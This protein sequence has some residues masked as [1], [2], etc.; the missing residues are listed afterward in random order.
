MT[1]QVAAPRP[2]AREA[3]SYV[4]S[5]DALLMPNPVMYG[6]FVDGIGG[7]INGLSAATVVSIYS[8]TA[9]S[10][11]E[12]LVGTTTAAPYDGILEFEWPLMKAYTKHTTFRVHVDAS[13]T[14][15]GADAYFSLGVRAIVSATTSATHVAPGKSVKLSASVYPASSA[16]GYV[17]FERL[18]GKS[19]KKIAQMKLSASGSYAKASFTWKPGKGTQKIRARYL[20]GTYNAGHWSPTKAI[21]VR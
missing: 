18:A 6:G 12:S 21:A 5:I 4:T 14:S 8:R 15:T 16:G 1:T 17:V 20:G 2:V 19:W 9:G 3:R 13:D 10:A 11:S 7:M